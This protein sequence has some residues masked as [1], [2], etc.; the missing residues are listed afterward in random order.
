MTSKIP[1][2][3]LLFTLL[4]AVSLLAQEDNAPPTRD[5][6]S[7]SAIPAPT[8]G[9]DLD[10]GLSII[11]PANYE[12]KPSDVVSL[13]VFQHNNLNKES[14]VEADGTIHLHLV[15]RVNIE[16][17]TVTEAREKITALYNRDFLVNPQ[18][19]LQVIEFDLD[20]VQILG[21]VRTPGTVGIPP[22]KDLT[23][24]QAIARVGGFTRLARQGTV[25]I[26]RTI[27]SGETKVFV[28]DASDLISDPNSDQFV[29]QNGD[30]VYVQE[31]I[32]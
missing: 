30:I 12:I 25:Q 5:Y 29:L 18:I 24:I 1:F 26:R 4:S 15:G 3:L 10:D 14:R 23:L 11:A 28:I 17:M 6:G 8:P 13:R 27:E 9:G 22:E 31:R 2:F 16:G 21:Q 7:D 32:F 20:R 19:D